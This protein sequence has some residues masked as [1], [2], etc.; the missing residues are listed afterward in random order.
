MIRI[1]IHHEGHEE[2]EGLENETLH[3]L[4]A[5]RGKEQTFYEFIKFEVLSCGSGLILY[6]NR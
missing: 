5:L 6:K 3:A 2:H 4:H 1:F